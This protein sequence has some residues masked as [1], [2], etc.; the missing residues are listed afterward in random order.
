LIGVVVVQGGYM[1]RISQGA[2]EGTRLDDFPKPAQVMRRF[3]K[4]GGIAHQFTV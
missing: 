2:F 4:H 1:G 3:V